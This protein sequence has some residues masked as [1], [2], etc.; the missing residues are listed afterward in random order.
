MKLSVERVEELMEQARLPQEGRELIRKIRSSEP[1]RRVSPTSSVTG[2]FPSRKM[3]LTIQYE[4]RTVEG[5]ACLLHETDDQVLEFW[6][7]PHTF[8]FR[9]EVPGVGRRTLKETPDFLVIGIVDG[10][11]FFRLEQWRTDERME[12]LG[13]SEPWRY[14]R[15][16]N[17]WVHLPVVE[18]L[19]SIGIPYC[20]RLRSEI[21]TMLV[22]NLEIL[23]PFDPESYVLS[24]GVRERV[25]MAVSE[26]PG[27]ILA[28]LL[29]H[30]V[31]VPVAEV[32]ALARRNDIHI[33]L[34]RVV[35][36]DHARVQVYPDAAT[37][38]LLAGPTLAIDGAA[39]EVVAGSTV[40][41]AGMEL[42]IKH[43]TSE[44]VFLLSAKGEAV[45]FPRVQFLELARAGD[46]VGVADGRRS[47]AEEFASVD[48]GLVEQAE[49]RFERIRPYVDGKATPSGSTERRWVRR[50]RAAAKIFG[51]GKPG[52]VASHAAKGNRTPR[53]DPESTQLAHKTM[54][55]QMLQPEKRSTSAAFSVY[56]YECLKLG[57]EPMGAT[58]FYRRAKRIK[59]ST[60]AQAIWGKK[61]A[62]AIALRSPIGGLSP[63]GDCALYR[64][65]I[66]HTPFDV[67]TIDSQGT[68]SLGT[69]NLS[70]ARDAYSSAILA[71]VLLFDEP[72]TRSLM[73][74][75]R[76][77]VRR[78]G[79]FAKI[80]VCDAGPEFGSTYFEKLC[81][82]YNSRLEKREQ[83]DARDGTIVESGFAEGNRELAWLLRGN[84]Q[85]NERMR[86]LSKGH[87]PSDRAVWTLDALYDEVQR[88]VQRHN[89]EWND[90][91]Q[92]TPMEVL[93]RS[94]KAAGQSDDLVIPF[95]IAFRALTAFPGPK[96]GGTAKVERS[97]V[98]I[99]KIT[100]WCEAFRE[101]GV[102]GTYVD[103]SYEPLNAAIGYARV[104]GA[105]HVC[106]SSVRGLEGLTEKE[107]ALASQ[108]LRQ[109]LGHKRRVSPEEFGRYLVEL[110]QREGE[111]AK[112]K[113]ARKAAEQRALVARIDPA[114]QRSHAA[115]G[116]PS[117]VDLSGVRAPEGYRK[118]DLK[119]AREEVQGDGHS[120]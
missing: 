11:P 76:E 99:N 7:Q 113:E 46:I 106:H 89:N 114:P 68:K 98:D 49:A 62:K 66:D 64:V 28:D 10:R 5:P 92:G 1:Q 50:Y 105:W 33:S 48:K 61:A 37:A 39:V 15:S 17:G 27:C 16:P 104:K 23:E 119:T 78:F 120:G 79:R 54:E 59:A 35:I 63:D 90:R 83:G 32:Y 117:R 19:K 26:N 100:Y 84:T 103:V 42:T 38:E 116:A 51:D 77:I 91:I 14:Q 87:R 31:D 30:L 115:P 52:L 45:Q 25:S 96:R 102:V 47:I 110:Q 40:R 109:S 56:R 6:D 69:A 13:Q 22:R 88:F 95:D 85:V 75:A 81:A 67:E 29:A 3:G 58:A 44:T 70:V 107:V 34:R 43:L 2:R 55:A 21:D 72:S 101:A 74:V 112:E 94:L 97:G 60:R 71:A 65:H 80:F 9:Y 53:L 86:E 12:R 18:H 111:L 73:L 20:V 4:S 8:Q 82:R 108:K 24:P 118:R 93:E 57:L 36:T 41:W